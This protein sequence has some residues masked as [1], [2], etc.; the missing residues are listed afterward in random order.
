MGYLAW[1]IAKT[2]VITKYL[3]ELKNVIQFV[4]GA[5]TGYRYY[6]SNVLKASVHT[7]LNISPYSF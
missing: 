4:L 1:L 6:Y 7:A 5:L 2:S 3:D